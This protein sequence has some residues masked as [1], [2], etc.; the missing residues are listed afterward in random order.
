MRE[1]PLGTER[2]LTQYLHFSIL[3]AALIISSA[4]LA[5]I[6]NFDPTRIAL[7]GPTAR[8]YLAGI[9]RGL[10]IS[11]T[12]LILSFL[13]ALLWSDRFKHICKKISDWFQ[14]LTS[15]RK[16]LVILAICI[17][18][19]FGAHAGNIL[20]G[21]FNMDDLEIVG[22]NRTLPFSE[23]VLMPHGNDHAFPLFIAEMKALDLLF[24]LSPLPYNLFFYLLF[25][26]IPFFTYLIFKRLNIGIDGFLVFLIFFSGAPAWAE[27]ISSFYIMSVYPQVILFFAMAAWSYLAW[28]DTTRMRYLIVLGLALLAALAADTSGIWVIPGMF[29]FM[30]FATYALR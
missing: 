10:T 23:S 13:V 22:L 3:G 15:L 24:D 19:S 1:G 18:F 29:F 17:V 6:K 9:E 28:R 4:A 26:L 21:Y 12:I 11:T 16:D 20:H 30:V 25:A 27:I 8:I 7:F 14:A 5:V 2:S